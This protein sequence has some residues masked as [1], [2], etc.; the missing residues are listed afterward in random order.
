MYKVEAKILYALLKYRCFVTDLFLC[1]L[2]IDNQWLY[3]FVHITATQDDKKPGSKT[4]HASTQK[5]K[6]RKVYE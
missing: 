4:D 2:F 6:N 3:T 1:L 5:G